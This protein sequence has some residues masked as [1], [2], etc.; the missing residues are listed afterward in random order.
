MNLFDM[1]VVQAVSE[2]QVLQPAGH[3]IQV[4]PF[5]LKPGPQVIVAVANP[6]PVIVWSIIS[7]ESTS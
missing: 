5:S 6:F 1:Q 4:L 7:L 2:V 3:L